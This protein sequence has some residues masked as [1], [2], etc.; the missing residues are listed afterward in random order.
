MFPLVSPIFRVLYLYLYKSLEFSQT[1]IMITIIL[2]SII[3]GLLVFKPHGKVQ[4]IKP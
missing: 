3:L 2:K 1:K 4:I